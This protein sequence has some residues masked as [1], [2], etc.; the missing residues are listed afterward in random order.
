MYADVVDIWGANYNVNVN[1]HIGWHVFIKGFFD[2]VPIQIVKLLSKSGF[3]GVYID[4]GSNIG[5]TSIP[6]AIKG[7][8]VI[9]VEASPSNAFELLKNI[10][11]NKAAKISVINAAAGDT[12]KVHN[13]SFVKLFRNEGNL[14]STSLVNNWNDSD[15]VQTFEYAAIINLDS[16]C[17][18][19]GVNE[20]LAV[21]IDVEGCEELVLRGFSDKLNQYKPPVLFEWRLD[22]LEKSFG[23]IPNIK[24]VFPEDYQFYSISSKGFSNL[25]LQLID[26]FALSL[27]EADLSKSHDNVL[28]ISKNQFEKSE[29]LMSMTT[30][31][32][33]PTT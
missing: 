15:N 24:S 26:N 28:A 2:P 14:G 29:L 1:D 5:T 25:G 18:C 20:F 30:R 9:C 7:Y 16:I 6:L 21:K 22:H 32:V 17:E 4:V 10:S 19:F 3:S 8:D 12:S 11:L 31:Y 27:S 23:N 33:C 13:H